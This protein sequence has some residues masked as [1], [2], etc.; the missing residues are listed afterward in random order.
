MEYEKA[1]L[2]GA[3]SLII[4]LIDVLLVTAF[5]SCLITGNSSAVTKV[6]MIETFVMAAIGFVLVMRAGKYID[7]EDE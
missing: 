6:F 7:E 2:N 3:V 4:Y 1:R 5:I